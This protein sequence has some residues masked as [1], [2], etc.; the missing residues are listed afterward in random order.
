M[1]D[2]PA[3]LVVHGPAPQR[4][5]EQPKRVDGLAQVVARR[6]EETR[7]R[8]I[9]LVGALFLLAHIDGKL[10]ILEAQSMCLDDLPLHG[11]HDDG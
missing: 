10:E 5:D 6:G 3:G 11:E 8:S 1:V 9:S 7:L 2:K 4:P